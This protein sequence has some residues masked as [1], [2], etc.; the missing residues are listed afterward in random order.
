VWARDGATLDEYTR[1]H[2]L[3]KKVGSPLWQV[4]EIAR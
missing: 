2:F 4:I 1:A 3:M